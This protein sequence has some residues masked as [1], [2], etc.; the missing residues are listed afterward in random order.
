M[1]KQIL[2][3]DMN[4]QLLIICSLWIYGVNFLMTDERSFLGWMDVVLDS[5]PKFI[6][7]PLFGC[8][9]CMASFH[10]TLV[11]SA[12]SAEFIIYQW[13]LFC[14]SLCGLN[15]LISEIIWSE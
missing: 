14:V 7:K 5:V 12:F 11:Y 15:Y 1:R 3:S 8:T 2:Y 4:L 9:M 10:G 13:I 6:T